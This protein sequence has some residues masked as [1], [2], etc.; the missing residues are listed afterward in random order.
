MLERNSAGFKIDHLSR[1]SIAH[2]S[3]EGEPKLNINRDG[4]VR[5][6]FLGIGEFGLQAKRN[7]GI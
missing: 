5:S 4:E 1:V 2:W 3:K 7:D 6:K